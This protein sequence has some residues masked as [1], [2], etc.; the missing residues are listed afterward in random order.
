MAKT[1]SLLS[2]A[3]AEFLGTLL[4]VFIS[5][6]S[7]I[8]SSFFAIPAYN[9][10]L[11][12]ALATGLAFA[13]AVSATINISGGHINPA[14]TIGILAARKI[15]ARDALTYII[16]Q[17]IGATAGAYLLFALFQNNFGSSVYWGTPTIAVFLS[18]AQAI[19]IETILTFILV[20]IVFGT[21]IDSRAPKLGGMGIGLVVIING[22]VGG[23]F[24]GAVMNPARWIGPALAAQ[25][26][27][28]WYVYWV[29]PI[30]G[31]MIAALLYVKLVGLK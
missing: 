10:L 6:G 31:S 8:A 3:S 28:N 1:P 21:V 23:Y 24:T 11:F 15:K 27:T 25:Y 17:I 2:R 20:F 7:V 19:L 9:A 16:S 5:A 14:V 18:P 12:V 22:M 4:F 26:F 13:L 30:L 29:G